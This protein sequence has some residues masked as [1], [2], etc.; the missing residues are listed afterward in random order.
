MPSQKK[1]KSNVITRSNSKD[2]TKQMSGLYNI[3]LN[4]LILNNVLIE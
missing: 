1:P 4:K 2:D 3:K